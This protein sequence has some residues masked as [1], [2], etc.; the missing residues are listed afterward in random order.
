MPIDA[1]FN[2]VRGYGGGTEN[3]LTYNVENFALRAETFSW[4]ARRISAWPPDSTISADEVAYIDRHYIVLDH[5]PLVARQA[6][7]HIVGGIIS[8]PSM[9]SSAAD[10]GAA[11]PTRPNFQRY[12]NSI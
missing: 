5:T 10:C 2:Y 12:G 4:R 8:S 3:S 1:P 9:G 6:A 7:S 11:S